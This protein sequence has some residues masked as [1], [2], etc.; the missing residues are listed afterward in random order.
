[1]K[2]V[3]L[4]LLVSLSVS[5]ATAYTRAD[6]LKI[7]SLLQE[8]QKLKQQPKSWMLWFGKKFIGVPYVAGTLDKT[9]EERLVVNTRQ[10][11][12]TTYVEMVTALTLC[13]QQGE[14][15]FE[16]Y[17]EHLRHVR[18]IGGKVEY[19]QRQ[20]YFTVWIND[21][22]R[23]GIVSDV[24]PNPPFTAVQK[25]MVESRDVN[26]EA[27]ASS[28]TTPVMIF[29]TEAM[30]AVSSALRSKYTLPFASTTVARSASMFG[31]WATAKPR[32]ST[33]SPMTISALRTSAYAS[34]TPPITGVR[35]STNTSTH[36]MARACLLSPL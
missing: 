1:M 2:K 32:E 18:Y 33:V 22:V 35:A 10:L 14:T 23:E 17:C 25:V 7:V 6:S 12:C 15:S 29:V 5:Y 24:N 26:P 11:D 8:A 20:H 16:K 31:H 21:N 30:Q 28:A 4:L 27:T 36:A 13:A 9:K 34:V 19:T 3:L